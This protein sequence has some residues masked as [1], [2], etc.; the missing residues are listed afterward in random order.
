M[1]RPDCP[2][3]ITLNSVLQARWERLKN[4]RKSIFITFSNELLE[5]IIIVNRKKQNLFSRTMITLGLF[6]QDTRIQAAKEIL[7]AR[8]L[9]KS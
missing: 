5:K 6:R 2:G 7:K 3:S 8:A 1:I 4:Q 9:M